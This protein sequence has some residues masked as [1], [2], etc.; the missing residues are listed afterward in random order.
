[1]DKQYELFEC[2]AAVRLAEDSSRNEVLYLPAGLQQITP[3]KGPKSV[4]V[5]VDRESAATME[6]HRRAVESR[7]GKRVYFDFKHEDREASFWPTGFFWKEGPR[8]GVYARGEFSAAGASGT[9][10]RMW[11]EFSPRCWLDNPKAT[12][13]NPAR[14]AINPN[15]KPNFGGFVNDGALTASPSGPPG[16]PCRTGN[17]PTNTRL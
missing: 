15:A 11:R 3:L 8:P 7:S 4:A 2:L 16:S 10:G 13:A 1:M 6:A 9:E 14:I 5:L 17:Q 12:P